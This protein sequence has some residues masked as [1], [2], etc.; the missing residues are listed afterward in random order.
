MGASLMRAFHCKFFAFRGSLA[1]VLL[2]AALASI[3]F[4]SRTHGLHYFRTAELVDSPKRLR[5]PFAV[6]YTLAQ[7]VGN[8]NL[9]S[10][11]GTIPHLLLVGE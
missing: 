4:A 1:R 9:L 2:A 3:G 10:S 5:R 8:L 6:P 11:A 7:T